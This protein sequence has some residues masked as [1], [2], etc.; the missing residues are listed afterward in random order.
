MIVVKPKPKQIIITMANQ[1]KRKQH[2]EPMRT[3][4]ANTRKRRKARENACDQ[5]AIGFGFESDWLSRWREFFNHRVITVKALFS[6]HL[7]IK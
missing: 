3:V 7:S 4:E 2:N 6:P 1:N 5:D